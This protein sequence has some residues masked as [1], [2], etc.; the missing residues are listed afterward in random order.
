MEAAAN[1]A[2]AAAEH[3]ETVPRQVVEN[4]RAAFGNA[5]SFTLRTLAGADHGLSEKPMQRAYTGVPVG[6]FDRNAGRRAR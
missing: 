1:R 4:Y 5:G 3:D 6:W 2:L